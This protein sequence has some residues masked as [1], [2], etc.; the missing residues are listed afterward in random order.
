[1]GDQDNI[2]QNLRTYVNAFSSE[3]RD[4]FNRFEFEA[5]LLTR[6][7]NDNEA[8]TDCRC[9]IAAPSP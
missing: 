8:T 1:M 3:V 7:Q 5:H 9:S 4:I 2:A 6:P